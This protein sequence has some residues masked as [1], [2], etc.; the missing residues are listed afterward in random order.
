MNGSS[1]P[2]D[3]TEAHPS[4]TEVT[5]GVELEYVLTFPRSDLISDSDKYQ[6]PNKAA[7]QMVREALSRPLHAQC[8]ICDLEVA[9]AL[10][11]KLPNPISADPLNIY[12]KWQVVGEMLH[13]PLTDR[14]A[15]NYRLVRT[16]DGY[17]FVGLE[18]ISR[19]LRADQFID[20]ADDLAD[21]VHRVSWAE[22]V[23]AV[24]E[25]LQHTFGERFR[26]N[27]SKANYLYSV[28]GAGLHIHV[29]NGQDGFSLD[30]V[31]NIMS[32]NAA[33]ERQVDTIQ[34]SHRIGVTDQPTRPLADPTGH[35]QQDC[36]SDRFVHNMGVIGGIQTRT[37]YRRL[38][39]AGTPFLFTNPGQDYPSTSYGKGSVET[40]ADR[41]DILAYLE[42]IRQADT[43]HEVCDLGLYQDKRVSQSSCMLGKADRK[44][45]QSATNLRELR[46][47]GTHPDAKK[48]IEFRQHRSTLQCAAIIP[49]LTFVVALVNYCDSNN[50]AAL[51]AVF[52]DYVQK[53]DLTFPDVCR[54]IG[55]DQKTVQFYEDQ[56]SVKYS[57]NLRAKEK[58]RAG[59]AAEKGN[60]LGA[61]AC[62]NVRRERAETH[63]KNAA[64]RIEEKFLRGGY[65]QF[66]QSFIDETLGSTSSVTD[67]QRQQITLG[68]KPPMR[69]E[70]HDREPLEPY[71]SAPGESDGY[72]TS[73]AESA[74]SDDSESEEVRERRVEASEVKGLSEPP[75]EVT[76]PFEPQ[77][78]HHHSSFSVGLS[79]SVGS[80]W[81]FEPI[82]FEG[83]D[84]HEICE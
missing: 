66:S 32:F 20:V 70:S 80:P 52:Q 65:G 84:G 77:A 40:A 19:I 63:P 34:A 14:R 43:L 79:S 9:F 83:P 3:E 8:S 81:L 59:A 72:V 46:E 64:K 1:S 68:Y 31:K 5:F 54:L 55:C 71:E 37:Y 28:P 44:L 4:H 49:W 29:G 16:E 11:L 45:N 21:H 13:T 57:R 36:N 26:S 10:P 75:I 25:R 33:F 69:G 82:E 60:P 61:L 51:Q 30:T 53:S 74:N 17:F 67:R 18:I 41:D 47:A 2:P 7:Q 50:V 6:G 56:L 24:T 78:I 12:D 42:L 23:K 58:K 76:G 38:A 22:E 73:E 15:I 62:E 35:S 27:H 39:E 48:T